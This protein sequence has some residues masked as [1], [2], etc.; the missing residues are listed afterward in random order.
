MSPQQLQSHPLLEWTALALGLI[1]VASFVYF[2][3]AV[4]GHGRAAWSSTADRAEAR[5]RDASGVFEHRARETRT[6][7]R[8]APVEH[9][10]RRDVRSA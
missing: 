8:A 4:P 5:I 9:V 2:G 6:G 1:G 3:P 7:A 10:R